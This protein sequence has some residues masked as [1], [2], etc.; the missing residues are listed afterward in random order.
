V[1]RGGGRVVGRAGGLTPAARGAVPTG[2]ARC[3]A[4]TPELTPGAIFCR[5]FTMD[6]D[7]INGGARAVNKTVCGLVTGVVGCPPFFSCLSY[8]LFLLIHPFAPG[9]SAQHGSAWG[10]LHGVCFTPAADMRLRSTR[11]GRSNCCECAIVAGTTV[12][13]TVSQWDRTFQTFCERRTAGGMAVY[14]SRS[15]KL[16]KRCS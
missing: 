15:G 16:T 13:V 3:A 9:A 7:F 14:R 12:L 2:L 10:L 11:S 8:P 5:R 4:L 6:F 1:P